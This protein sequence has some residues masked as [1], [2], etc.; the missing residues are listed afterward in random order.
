M[1]RPVDPQEASGC[2]WIHGHPGE[3]GWRYCQAPQR[4]GS[5]FC[6]EHHIRC[7]LVSADEDREAAE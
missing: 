3:K 6:E 7:Y 5:Q 4:R 2:R 1:D